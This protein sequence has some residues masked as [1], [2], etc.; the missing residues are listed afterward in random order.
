MNKEWLEKIRNRMIVEKHHFKYLNSEK[1]YLENVYTLLEY[2]MKYLFDTIIKQAEQVQELE[3]DK[4]ALGD[5]I[6]ETAK[7]AWNIE[8]QN[9][10]YR[11]AKKQIEE[12]YEY[13]QEVPSGLLA[14]L[15]IAIKILDK[16]LEGE[17]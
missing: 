6:E 4:K 16:A 10:L 7:I 8:Q 15:S 9:K 2:D 1:G 3:E 17:K 5:L 13:F 12:K 14:G 11:E